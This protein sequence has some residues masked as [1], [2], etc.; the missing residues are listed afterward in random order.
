MPEKNSKTI[1][2]SIE[3]NRQYHT[4]YLRAINSPLRRG[5]LKAMKKGCE[6][7][8]ELKSSTGLDTDTLRW[9]LSVLEHGF[10]VEKDTKKG[11]TI[12]KLTQEGR[13]VDYL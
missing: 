8:E 1:S 11:K 3:E 7:I 6:T 2:R 5:I 10:C 12:Y 9:H 4:R 13:V